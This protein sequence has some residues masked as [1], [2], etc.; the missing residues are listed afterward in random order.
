LALACGLAPA[1]GENKSNQNWTK[2]DELL[3]QL[4]NEAENLSVESERLWDLLKVLSSN[5]QASEIA[6]S[7]LSS[8]LA[9]SDESWKSYVDS[10]DQELSRIRI[11]LWAW[12]IGV[13]L[14]VAGVIVLL[15]R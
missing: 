5:L 1:Q 6:V 11:E 8:S 7:A 9:K 4:E 15:L 13:V 2:L 12:R 3:N 14:G 10:K